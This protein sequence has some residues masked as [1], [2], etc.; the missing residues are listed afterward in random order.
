MKRKTVFRRQIHCIS[1]STK[2]A[3]V[4][5]PMFYL[6]ALFLLPSLNP[7]A[8]TLGGKGTLPFISTKTPQSK[9]GKITGH[10]N[11]SFRMTLASGK[12]HIVVLPPLNNRNML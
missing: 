7:F 12:E 3:F 2:E 5:K 6:F 9:N 11:N 10:S 4:S 1:P 8:Q